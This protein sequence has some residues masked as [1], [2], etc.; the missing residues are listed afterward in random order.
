[1]AP[2]IFH[3]C[4]LQ[5]L[6]PRDNVLW[7]KFTFLCLNLQVC[8]LS[9]FSHV[10]LFGTLWTVALQAPLSMGF[11]RQEL[12]RGLPFTSS[13]GF[14]TQGSNLHLLHL[15]HWQA[16]TLLLAPYKS[17]GGQNLQ[18]NPEI[19][20]FFSKDIFSSFSHIQRFQAAHLAVDCLCPLR[21]ECYQTRDWEMLLIFSEPSELNYYCWGEKSNYPSNLLSSWPRHPPPHN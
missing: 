7:F 1:M 15:L 3:I 10:W 21:T 5:N 13:G 8:V 4:H 2:T 14:P 12:W 17:K 9:H 19:F 11:S 16:S 6:S 18:W 20:L